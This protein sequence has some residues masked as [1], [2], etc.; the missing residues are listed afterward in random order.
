MGLINKLFGGK[1]DKLAQS[2]PSQFK[3]SL[4]AVEQTKSRNAPRRELVQVVLRDTMRKHGIP[5]D[6]IDCRILSV[7]TRQHKSGVHVQFLVRKGDD[8]LLNYVHAFQESFWKEMGRF[9]PQVSDWLFSVAWQFYGKATRDFAPVVDPGSWKDED[10]TQPPPQLADTQPPRQD[11]PEELAS[12]LQTLQ[13]LMSRPA[14]LAEL[15]QAKPRRH[16]GPGET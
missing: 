12:D 2:V 9:D 10:D 6:W 3:E 5:T 15:P 11:D 4:T 7:M 14:D 13:A 1:E 16:R 8:Q